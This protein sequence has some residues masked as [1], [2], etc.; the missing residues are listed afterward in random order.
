MDLRTRGKR[1][2]RSDHHHT[3]RHN[4]HLH[5]YTAPARRERREREGAERES[6]TARVSGFRRF[7][8]ELRFNL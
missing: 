4:H 1:E 2:T 5:H 3:T 7:S 8:A 6:S